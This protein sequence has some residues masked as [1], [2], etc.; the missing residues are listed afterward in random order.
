MEKQEFLN[1]LSERLNLDEEK[2][3]KVNDILE[4]NFLIGKEN[5]E[6]IIDSFKGALDVTEEVANNIYEAAMDIIGSGLLDAIKHP[7]KDKDEK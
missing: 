2:V 7:F 3:K 6:K 1:K 5:K 4:D